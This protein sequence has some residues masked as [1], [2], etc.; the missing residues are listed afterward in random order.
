MAFPFPH[1]GGNAF[2]AENLPEEPEAEDE[3]RTVLEAIQ[4]SKGYM[5]ESTL[6]YLQNAPP[7]TAKGIHRR[8]EALRTE[9][10]VFTNRY[11]PL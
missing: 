10:A 7:R 6:S 5:S 8:F 11:N 9:A 4:T 3:A 1:P 2:L